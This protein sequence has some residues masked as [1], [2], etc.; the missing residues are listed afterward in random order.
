M[1]QTLAG[2]PITTAAALPP[3]SNFPLGVTTKQ[4]DP[5]KP[6]L[7]EVLSRQNAA[8]TDD[9][10]VIVSTA[11][12]LPDG[13]VTH[14][15]LYEGVVPADIPA[16]IIWIPPTAAM[17]EW[18]SDNSNMDQ[19]LKATDVLLGK[20]GAH[21]IPKGHTTYAGMNPVYGRNNLVQ[22]EIEESILAAWL[23]IPTVYRPVGIF[24]CR[25]LQL[26]LRLLLSE[27][28]TELHAG[29][30][31]TDK[32]DSTPTRHAVVRY[33][34]HDDSNFSNLPRVQ[35]LS[36][37]HALGY[38]CTDAVADRLLAHN[39]RIIHTSNV[40][41]EPASAIE[42]IAIMDEQGAIAGLA[43]QHHPERPSR[44]SSDHAPVNDNEFF[45]WMQQI[46]SQRLKAVAAQSASKV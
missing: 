25:S 33:E 13:T 20:G 6:F 8:N 2:L 41:G 21:P 9:S 30:A 46:V 19:L 4:Y 7:V 38:I 37:H 26:F 10:V 16:R 35:S 1:H 22:D 11:I 5:A 39:V 40:P 12:L 23:K 18:L 3:S 34:P 44:W 24:T 28:P 29:H 43:L 17:R 42:S 31:P 45:A 14:R 32:A 36:S 15:D 27:E